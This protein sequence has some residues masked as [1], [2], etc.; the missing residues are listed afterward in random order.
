MG[1]NSPK[2]ASTP[3]PPHAVDI[4]RQHVVQQVIARRNRGEHLP[5]RTCC[6]TRV[7]GTLRCS[8][9][10]R[11][12][13]ASRHYLSLL[14]CASSFFSRSSI[15]TR[16]FLPVTHDSCRARQ[17]SETSERSSLCHVRHASRSCPTSLVESSSASRDCFRAIPEIL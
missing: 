11:R 7:S 16:C 10:Y 6:S 2:G 8:A 3:P 5:H 13:V 12:S 4:E 15:A 9:D 1:Q 14:I 17:T